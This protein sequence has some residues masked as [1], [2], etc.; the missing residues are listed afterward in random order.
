[1]FL[2]SPEMPPPAGEN[3]DRTL[4]QREL[5]RDFDGE[6]K[7]ARSATRPRREHCSRPGLVTLPPGVTSKGLC[8]QERGADAL[9]LVFVVEDSEEDAIHRGSVGEHTHWPGSPPD[10]AKAPLDG[11]GGANGFALA[12][13]FV[14]PAREQLVE[15]VT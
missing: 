14:A 4:E 13:G 7:R 5:P 9:V 2:P 1:M 10:F 15:I 8:Q 3:F 12:E 6:S 11:I